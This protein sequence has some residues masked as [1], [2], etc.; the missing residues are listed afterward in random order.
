MLT[1]AN[2]LKEHVIIHGVKLVPPFF[3]LL[4]FFPVNLLAKI[5][6]LRTYLLAFQAAVIIKGMLSVQGAESKAVNI[7]RQ[8]SILNKPSSDTSGRL[9]P[10]SE[11]A[12]AFQLKTAQD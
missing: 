10:S 9:V 11:M 5:G 12:Q 8:A 7:S 1:S 3:L 2:L 4:F 6:A